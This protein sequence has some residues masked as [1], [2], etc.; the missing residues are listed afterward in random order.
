MHRDV[1]PHNVMID[2]EQRKARPGLGLCN[3]VF[4]TLFTVAADRLGSGRILPPKN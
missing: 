2:H 1:K 4:L 3:L